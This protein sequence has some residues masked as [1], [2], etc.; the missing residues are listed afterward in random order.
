MDISITD[1]IDMQIRPSSTT[2]ALTMGGYKNLKGC[3]R[4]VQKVN[5]WRDNQILLILLA[6]KKCRQRG[7]QEF[8]VWFRI[9]CFK[10]DRLLRKKISTELSTSILTISN[11]NYSIQLNNIFHHHSW[12][13]LNNLKCSLYR[14]TVERP[15]KNLNWDCIRCMPTRLDKSRGS[16]FIVE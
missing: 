9:K 4:K 8:Q 7:L 14:K 12:T 15:I 3:G 5:S 10:I 2:M 16:G 13:K 6:M 1:T 11:S